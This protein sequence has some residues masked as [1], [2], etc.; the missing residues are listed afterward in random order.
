MLA[1]LLLNLG[2]TPPVVSAVAARRGM[3]WPL[4]RFWDDDCEE[5]LKVLEREEKKVEKQIAKLET[6][7]VFPAPASDPSRVSRINERTTR[8]LALVAHLEE[9]KIDIERLRQQKEEDEMLEDFIGL[10]S[11]E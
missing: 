10:L 5:E 9:V 2:A 8:V 3:A 7:L 1:A 6:K 4:V 11:E